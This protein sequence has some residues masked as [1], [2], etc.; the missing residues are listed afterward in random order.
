MP[1]P[2]TGTAASASSTTGPHSTL[3]A[4]IL[5]SA[6]RREPARPIASTP[7]SWRVAE[8]ERR[9]AGAAL[10][11]P[12]EASGMASAALRRPRRGVARE[13]PTAGGIP[14]RLPRQWSVPLRSD[15]DVRR[16][17]HTL[18]LMLAASSLLGRREELIEVLSMA[19]IISALPAPPLTA[20][21]GATVQLGARLTSRVRV[22]ASDGE[23]AKVVVPVAAAAHRS[24]G[25]RTPPPSPPL[26][27]VSLVTRT[28]NTTTP[29]ATATIWTPGTEP[30]AGKRGRGIKGEGECPE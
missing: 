9:G 23:G 16:R 24:S 1:R 14:G 20:H 15:P 5:F 12:A 2:L 30:R 17:P 25:M 19:S 29:P 8:E 7:S 18:T 6:L 28:P 11:T 26:T 3:P 22:T 10:G 21:E 4:T 13:C 27:P